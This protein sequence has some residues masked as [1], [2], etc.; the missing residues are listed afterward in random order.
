MTEALAG[1]ADMAGENPEYLA[2]VAAVHDDRCPLAG[3]RWVH[4][5]GGR[6]VVVSK[7]I[8][9]A[10]LTPAVAYEADGEPASWTWVRPLS[11]FLDGRFTRVEG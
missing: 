4:R 9:E 5:N 11:E 1:E 7:C 2:A 6:Y 8:I 3:S 10:T